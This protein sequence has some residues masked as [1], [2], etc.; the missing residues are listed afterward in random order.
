MHYLRH[1]NEVI[2]SKVLYCKALRYETIKN[3]KKLFSFM[4]NLQIY[5]QFKLDFQK[6]DQHTAGKWLI[7][8][9]LVQVMSMAQFYPIFGTVSIIIT[10]LFWL[11]LV[12][13]LSWAQLY[14][15]YLSY[16]FCPN[17]KSFIEQFTKAYIH[18]SSRL[19]PSWVHLAE[20]AV[21][22]SF[23]YCVRFILTVVGIVAVIGLDSEPTVIMFLSK[24]CF[25]LVD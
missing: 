20:S 11:L 10:A 2:E 23:W 1:E 25:I 21:V 18:T 3:K 12:L 9:T 17:S 24:W 5:Y 15:D 4:S 7:L 14:S 6:V 13:S 22:Y 19:K 16:S 8:L